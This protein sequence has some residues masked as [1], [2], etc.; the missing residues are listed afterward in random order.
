MAWAVEKRAGFIENTARRHRRGGQYEFSRPVTWCR[1]HR[2]R[3]CCSP[4]GH[5]VRNLR[6]GELGAEIGDSS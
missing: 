6:W 5:S 4:H 1:K 3:Y 2:Y